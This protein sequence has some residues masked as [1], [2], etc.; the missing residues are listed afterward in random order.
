MII[1]Q[2]LLIP[3]VSVLFI[4]LWSRNRGQIIFPLSTFILGA[5]IFFPGIFIFYLLRG[6][7]QLHF[8][9]I[10]LIIYFFGQDQLL[11]IVLATIGLLIIRK[12]SNIA[13]HESFTFRALAFYGGYYSLVSCFYY[14][15]N[16][17]HLNEY[18][19]FILPVM[20]LST[21]LIASIALGQFHDRD[22][23]VKILFLFG[24]LIPASAL[25]F[26]ST[27]PFRNYIIIAAIL[28][29]VFALLSTFL[30]VKLKD[31]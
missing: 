20:H 2:L 5:I 15:E 3:A 8:S 29:G 24:L 26:V 25:S 17:A 6:F 11:H 7:F 18:V 21:I 27:L 30:F 14:L 13:D 10:D 23:F 12:F 1:F 28:T 9:S 31:H 4:L 22:G 16:F 19:L